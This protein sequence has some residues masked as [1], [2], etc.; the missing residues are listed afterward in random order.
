MKSFSPIQFRLAPF[1]G[2]ACF[3]GF[4][5]GTFIAPRTDFSKRREVYAADLT[6]SIRQ[7]YDYF[8][9]FYLDRDALRIRRGSSFD[10]MS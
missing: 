9:I 2:P 5:S 4:V 3:N 6:Q 8:A 10:P 1:R 7:K